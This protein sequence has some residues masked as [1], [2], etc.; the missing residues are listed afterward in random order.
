VGGGRRVVGGPYPAAAAPLRSSLGLCVPTAAAANPLPA[1]HRPTRPLPFAAPPA[2]RLQEID[3]GTP[4]FV[5]FCKPHP[6]PAAPVR[7]DGATEARGYAVRG[8]Q[9]R[10]S[11]IA[12][13]AN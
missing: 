10:D 11:A 12:V 3:A 1:L 6:A 13:C 8:A 4:N 9:Q 7:A 2:W 5:L